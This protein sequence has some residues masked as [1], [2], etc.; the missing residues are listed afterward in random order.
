ML[1]EVISL[2]LKYCISYVIIANLSPIYKNTFEEQM[3]YY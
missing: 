1:G 2:Y 3:F